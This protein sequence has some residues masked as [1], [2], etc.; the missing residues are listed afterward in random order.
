VAAPRTSWLCPTPADR[1]RLIDMDR[2]LS[3]VRRASLLILALGL[4]VGGPWL[5]WWTLVP[6]VAAA[7]GFKAIE[8]GLETS[9]RPELRVAAAWGFAQ[10]AIAMSIALTGGPDSPA[11]AW[12]AIPLVTLPARFT[13]NGVAAGLVF[14]VVLLVAA[15]IGVDPG[16]VADNPTRVVGALALLAAVTVLSTALMRS[17]IEHR[18]DALIDPLTGMLNRNALSRRIDE[19]EQQAAIAQQPVALIMGDLDRFKQINDLHGH[20][21]GDAVL[22]ET[23]YRMRKYLRAFDSA[24]RLGGEEFL[25]VLPGASEHT[26]GTVAEGLRGAIAHHPIGGLAITMS[27]GVAASDPGAFDYQ[28]IAEMAD[29]RL[30][31]AKQTGRNRVVAAALD[32]EPDPEPEPLAAA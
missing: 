11:I 2:R 3:T 12:L 20:A 25:V 4:V 22:Q 17:D 24:Y 23:A 21:I 14:T 9:E 31:E 1:E 13:S 26:A 5:G 30:Y 16:A 28:E 15:T 32:D 29:R 27:F 6:L 10:L 19:L 18:S 8:R 7:A